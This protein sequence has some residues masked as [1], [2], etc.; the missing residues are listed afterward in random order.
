M[1]IVLIG[2]FLFLTKVLTEGYIGTR[3]LLFP[4]R[5]WIL[6]SGVAN[7]AS[8]FVGVLLIV[9]LNFAFLMATGDLLYNLLGDKFSRLI[10]FTSTI[11]IPFIYVASVGVESFIASLFVK[12]HQY[13]LIRSWSW[14]ANGVSYSFLMVLLVILLFLV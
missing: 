2:G 8:A 4:Y 9:L 5:R 6:I 7:T 11:W 14:R 13:S 3:Y 1:L 12:P 10:P